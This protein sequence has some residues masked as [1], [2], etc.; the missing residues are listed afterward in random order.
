[1]D[2][3]EH[4]HV[5]ETRHATIARE[6]NRDVWSRERR[7]DGLFRR[8]DPVLDGIDVSEPIR[9]ARQKPASTRY[10]VANMAPQRQVSISVA[11]VVTSRWKVGRIAISEAK[12]RCLV[13]VWT[14][15][16]ETDI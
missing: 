13:E 8:R 9:N 3:H 5:V 1:M 11:V 15:E 4:R 7:E 16:V 6:W 12:A 14:N 2:A 10:A